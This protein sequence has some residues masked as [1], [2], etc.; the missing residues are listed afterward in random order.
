MILVGQYD[1]PYVRRV[2]I[3]LRVLG[4]PYE[5]DTRSVFADFDAMRA[6]NPLGRIPSLVLADGQVLIDSG[7]ILDWLD[8]SVGPARALMP[9]S[10][11]LRLRALQRM[12]LATGGID[13]LG[14]ANYER[15]MRPEALRW[16]AWIARCL[17]QATGALI[18]LERETWSDR[19]DQA[20]IT[21]GC[22]LGYV[23]LTAPEM[24][25]PGRYPALDALWSR[26]KARDEFIATRTEHYALPKGR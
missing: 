22:F 18:A 9:P 25:P 8:Q 17:T 7:A 15:F 10:G 5:H 1:S 26:L 20:Q 14:A 21:T 13:K 19:L 4:I 6:T 16:P 24:M 12:A 23:E 2:A 3:S 11:E